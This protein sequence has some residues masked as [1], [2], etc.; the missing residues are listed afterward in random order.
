MRIR[1]GIELAGLSDVGCLRPNNEDSFAYW[2]PARSEQFKQTGRLVIVADGMGGHEGGQQASRIAVET[3]KEVYSDGSVDNP[4]DR[5]LAGLHAAHQ[6]ILLYGQKHPLLQGLGTTC[7]AFALV[8]KALYFA[9]IG[10]SRLYLLRDSKIQRLTHDHSYVGRLMDHGIIGTAEAAVHPHRN[11]LLKALGVGAEI[12][13]DSPEQ[14]VA[15]QNADILL[16]CT[17]GL[18]SVV[19]EDEMRGIVVSGTLSQAC[20]AL[21]D[22]AKEQGGPDNITVQLVRIVE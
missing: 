13:P 16:L 6:H 17:D 7:T 5:L 9:H 1:P 20:Q 22:K 12:E 2:E 21:V 3:V 8:G 15:L 4:R 10:D 11:I 19:S 14:P 18:W